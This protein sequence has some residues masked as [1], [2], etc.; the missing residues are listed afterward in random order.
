MSIFP[1]F[2]TAEATA[3]FAW[4][5]LETSH[6]T[7][8][9]LEPIEE[10]TFFAVAKSTSAITTFAPSFAKTRATP[11]PMPLLAPVI[12]ATLPLSLAILINSSPTITRRQAKDLKFSKPRAEGVSL[13]LVFQQ[14]GDFA[15]AHAL[16]T[17]GANRAYAAT[18]VKHFLAFLANHV[19][20]LFKEED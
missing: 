8:I 1:N 20:H 19:N 13:K 17:C 18:V 11:S 7:A 9:A 4:P 12:S 14:S 5:A 10:A 6:S 16:L 2:L 15:F 3:S